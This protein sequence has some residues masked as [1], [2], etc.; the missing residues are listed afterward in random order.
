MIDDV[1]DWT[2]DDW[3]ACA[4]KEG[5]ASVLPLKYFSCEATFAH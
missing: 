3:V 1:R 4:K 5:A 2:D